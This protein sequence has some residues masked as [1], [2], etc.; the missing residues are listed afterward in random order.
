[1]NFKTFLDNYKKK[2]KQLTRLEEDKYFRVL[3]YISQFKDSLVFEDPEMIYSV[4]MNNPRWRSVNTWETNFSKITTI[5]N[6]SDPKLGQ[7]YVDFRI[8]K[9]K[10]EVKQYSNNR[11][12]KT[13][14]YLEYD[15]D[16]YVDNYHKLLLN[17]YIKYPPLRTDYCTV[18][19]KNYD[20][21]KD[22]YYNDGTFYFNSLIKNDLKNNNTLTIT[23]FPEDR[24]IA[25][26]LKGQD[27]FFPSRNKDPSNDF[28]KTLQ[29]YSQEYFGESL[30][31]NDFR[32]RYFTDFMKSVKGLEFPEAYTKVKEIAKKSNTSIE[33]MI[34]YYYGKEFGAE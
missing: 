4:V 23:L 30:S 21:D 12:L 33:Q 3:D 17:L 24:Q 9:I 8:K 6:I 27:F 25:D 5:I 28:V 15:S 34:N 26:C 31:V 29:K 14:Q 7:K 22:N 1:M 18:K 2:V 19:L 13:F 20:K 11:I 16:D 10:P 32:R